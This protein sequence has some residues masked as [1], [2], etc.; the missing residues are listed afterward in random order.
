MSYISIFEQIIDFE[1]MQKIRP[2]LRWVGGKSWLTKEIESFIPEEFNNYYEPFLGGGAIFFYLKSKG[3]IK[4]RSYLSD[5]NAEL[6]NSYRVLKSYPE[7]LM[8]LLKKQKDTEKE[9]YRIKICK[10]DDPIERAAQFLYLNKTSFNGIYRVN[11]KGEYNVPYGKRYLKNLYDYDQLMEISECFKN[12]FFSTT[13][14]KVKCTLPEK[15]DLV[16]LD[17]PY[18]VAHENNGFIQYNQSLFSWENQIELSKIIRQLNAKGVHYVLTNANHAS[19]SSLYKNS[20]KAV[21]ARASTIGG[22]GAK[23]TKYNELIITDI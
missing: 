6:I 15:N 4:N 10:F 7:D 14:F 19:I 21:L 5:C 12:V 3:L 2:F 17:P 8:K 18:T 1:I 13:D 22:L 23:R 11:A 20:T 16:F 9:F